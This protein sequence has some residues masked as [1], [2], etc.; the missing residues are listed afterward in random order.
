[1]KLLSKLYHVSLH[2]KKKKNHINSLTYFDLKY[3]AMWKESQFCVLTNIQRRL[4]KLL[5]M[6]FCVHRTRKYWDNWCV[7]RLSNCILSQSSTSAILKQTVTFS[8]W[9]ITLN[10]QTSYAC[11]VLLW[12][13]RKRQRDITS[14]LETCL[15]SSL[16]KTSRWRAYRK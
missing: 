16:D 10:W 8:S 6:D 13:T 7:C 12:S 1:M 5:V 14:L 11:K 4:Y 2:L 9:K 15:H 3:A